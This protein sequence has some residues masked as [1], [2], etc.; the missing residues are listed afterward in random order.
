MDL[1]GDRLLDGKLEE[2]FGLENL[3]ANFNFIASMR[4]LG[5]HMNFDFD[6]FFVGLCGL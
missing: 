1:E 6:F 5:I 2:A 3:D 4:L